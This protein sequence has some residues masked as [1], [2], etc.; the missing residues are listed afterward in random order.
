MKKEDISDLTFSLK[1]KVVFTDHEGN[2]ESGV[3]VGLPEIGK[4]KYLV[5]LKNGT[6]PIN[7]C[8]LKKEQ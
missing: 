2:S 1:D 8:Y 7:P 4:T 6:Y 3:I 5:K